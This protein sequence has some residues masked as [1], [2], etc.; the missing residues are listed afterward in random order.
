MRNH[1]LV[2]N[3]VLCPVL[4]GVKYYITA[5]M[6]ARGLSH[7]S[8]QMV[9]RIRAG[10]V[11]ASGCVSPTITASA[12]CPPFS[13]IYDRYD[14]HLAARTRYGSCSQCFQR[15]SFPRL[16]SLVLVTLRQLVAHL[17]R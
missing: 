3:T 9:V 10:I 15:L 5:V 13:I 1:Y 2:L 16:C 6:V 14:L 17:C 8:T 4:P 12:T 11:L 7:L